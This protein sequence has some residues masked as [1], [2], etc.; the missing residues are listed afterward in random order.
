MMRRVTGEDR[1][2]SY[3]LRGRRSTEQRAQGKGHRAKG[4]GQRAWSIWHRAKGMEHGVKSQRLENIRIDS[5]LY[6]KICGFTVRFFPLCPMH[7]ARCSFL[8]PTA[9]EPGVCRLFQSLIS[10]EG[11]T[12]DSWPP[13]NY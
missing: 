5:I 2:S 4:I 8:P 9:T 3:G 1:V 12:G 11:Q 10:A 7:C 13:V 6:F